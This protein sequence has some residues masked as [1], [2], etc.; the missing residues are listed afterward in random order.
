MQTQGCQG[1][2]KIRNFVRNSKILIARSTIQ[3]KL[4]KIKKKHLPVSVEF[5]SISYCFF[6]FTQFWLDGRPG[7]EYFW[8]SRKISDLLTPLT[9]LDVHPQWFETDLSHSS[10][11]GIVWC[12]CDIRIDNCCFFYFF[13]AA[14]DFDFSNSKYSN[15]KSFQLWWT[16]FI[17]SLSNN[18]TAVQDEFWIFLC[19]DLKWKTKTCS[20]IYPPFIKYQ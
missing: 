16:S 13:S 7:N 19:Y 15:I 20:H 1:C 8:I 10:Y 2:Q 5:W 9:P 14:I 6:D 17:L 4:S 11:N 12:Q 18:L 3:S